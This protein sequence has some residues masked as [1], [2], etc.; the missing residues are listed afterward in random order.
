MSQKLC[1]IS[2]DLV[3]GLLDEQGLAKD[4]IDSVETSIL[5]SDPLLV[6]VVVKLNKPLAIT[7]EELMERLTKVAGSWNVSAHLYYFN[8]GG[9]WVNFRNAETS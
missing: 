2:E 7:C 3:T 4:H 6:S 5:S 9:F 8:K 1:S